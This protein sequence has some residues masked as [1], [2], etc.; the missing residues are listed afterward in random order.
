MGRFAVPTFVSKPSATS[1]FRARQQVDFV[2]LE[3]SMMSERDTAIVSP[4]VSRN[5]AMTRFSASGRPI[6]S[7]SGETQRRNRH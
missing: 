4:N 3:A 5:V 2:S 6:V 7:R 1:V